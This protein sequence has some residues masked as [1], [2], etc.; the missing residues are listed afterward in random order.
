MSRCDVCGEEFDEDDLFHFDDEL[1]CKDCVGTEHF[2]AD[3]S[4][5]DEQ[6]SEFA[7]M[8]RCMECGRAYESDSE[9]AE[10]VEE[11]GQCRKC[12]NYNDGD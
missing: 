7:D 3:D 9:D 1:Q 8:V 10:S 12:W 2:D 4:D 11:H 5:D 6:G